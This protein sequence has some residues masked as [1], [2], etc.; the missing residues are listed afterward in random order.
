MDDMEKELQLP[1]IKIKY[2]LTYKKVKNI[3][4][5]VKADG[6]VYISAP[7]RL[8]I[9]YLEEFM[10]SKEPFILSALKNVEKRL[11]N[12]PKEKEY[13]DGENIRIL[14]MEYTLKLRKAQRNSAEISGNEIILSLS[15]TENYDKKRILYETALKKYALDIFMGEINKIYPHFE[16]MGVSLPEIKVRKMKSRWGSCN[17]YKK[18]VT[19]NLQLMYTDMSCIHYVI[20]HEFSHF[21]H[22]NHSRNFYALVESIMPDWKISDRQLN[23]IIL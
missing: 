14:G 13:I 1:N 12:S 6:K 3:N 11:E 10:K 18:T 23:K 8:T 7:K 16:R 5:R 2:V 9:K 22:P 4:M 20:V 17:P 19:L 15:D 21:I